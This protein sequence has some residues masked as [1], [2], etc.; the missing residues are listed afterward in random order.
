MERHGCFAG[1]NTRHIYP[2]L[3]KTQNKYVECTDKAMPPHRTYLPVHELKC[4]LEHRQLIGGRSRCKYL[5]SSK[6]EQFTIFF[7]EYNDNTSKK[8]IKKRK[9]QRQV[10]RLR[11]GTAM[12]QLEMYK[13]CCYTP[14]PSCT[15][16][17]PTNYR[18]AGR[19]AQPASMVSATPDSF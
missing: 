13:E 16:V 10:P 12:L 7:T 15:G 9:P 14:G 1:M 8:E 19:T 4:S 2:F 11:K 17:P 3:S 6:S 5:R 18:A